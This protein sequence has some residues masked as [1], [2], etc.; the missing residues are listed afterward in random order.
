MRSSITAYQR[1]FIEGFSRPSFIV[2]ALAIDGSVNDDAV[3]DGLRAVATAQPLF[4]SQPKRRVGIPTHFSSLDMEAWL[5]LAPLR[6]GAEV[7]GVDAAAAAVL[8]A[9]DRIADGIPLEARVHR[10]RNGTVI[11]GRIHHAVADGHALRRL[12]P[13]FVSGYRGKP[14]AHR[15]TTPSRVSLRERAARGLTW[16][17]SA[18]LSAREAPPATA[19]SSVPRSDPQSW[20]PQVASHRLSSVA[21]SR[22]HDA[23]RH[24]I[25]VMLH[26]LMLACRAYN[27][28]R[29]RGFAELGLMVA[30]S[31]RGQRDYRKRDGAQV[32][33]RLLVLPD[34]LLDRPAAFVAHV[35]RELSARDRGHHDLLVHLSYGMRRL[36]KA[37]WGAPLTGVQLVFSDVSSSAL[38]F[39]RGLALDADV[40]VNELCAYVTPT[41]IDAAAMLVSRYREQLT[42]SLCWYDDAI[43]G[44]ALLAHFDSALSRTTSHTSD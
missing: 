40:A 14:T 33:T 24:R 4:R 44:A 26:A 3:R 5:A 12:L 31:R 28:E 29:N 21:A 36:R 1:L 37:R 39:R 25:A 19:T 2:I 7:E 8:D 43:D 22:W 27:Q 18:R 13:A 15:S 20:T 41:A 35:G 30:T 23:G 11:V 32:D 17:A 6:W 16:L 42:A 10:S 9:P 38:S 34:A